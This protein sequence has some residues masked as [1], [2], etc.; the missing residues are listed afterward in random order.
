MIEGNIHTESVES[1][2]YMTCVRESSVRRPQSCI[3]CPWQYPAAH[4]SNV[5]YPILHLWWGRKLCWTRSRKGYPSW[6]LVSRYSLSNVSGDQMK[7]TLM[8]Q[9]KS[10]WG[11]REKEVRSQRFVR[12]W[13]L[14]CWLETESGC[15]RRQC[16]PKGRSAR[17]VTQIQGL[18]VNVR[19]DW[20]R[21]RCNLNQQSFTFRWI[22][23]FPNI[24]SRRQL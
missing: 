2:G 24:L 3:G 18:L 9:K 7:V 19:L 15:A 8:V 10:S 23:P 12:K 16:P 21:Q 22:W 4:D 1:Y 14:S 6:G 20:R 17:S 11:V 13:C 5:G